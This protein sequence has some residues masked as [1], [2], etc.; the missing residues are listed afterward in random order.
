MR[1]PVDQAATSSAM[2]FA[3]PLPA[4]VAPEGD[5]PNQAEQDADQQRDR[6]QQ[7]INV[8]EVRRPCRRGGQTAGQGE[9]P[10]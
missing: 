2:A 10:R 9:V 3:P 1:W 8:A 7:L 5:Q 6:G 4:T